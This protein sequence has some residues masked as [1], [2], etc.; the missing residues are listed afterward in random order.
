MLILSTMLRWTFDFI[1][2]TPF[3]LRM[4]AQIELVLRELEGRVHFR[5]KRDNKVSRNRSMS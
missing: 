5:M 3:S 1:Q 2:Y 4:A